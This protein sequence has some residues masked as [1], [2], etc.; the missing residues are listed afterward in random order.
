MSKR[1]RSNTSLSDNEGEEEE[2]NFT[3]SAVTY[4]E[5]YNDPKANVVLVAA[6]GVRFR[7]D[8]FY[9]KGNR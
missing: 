6:D 7:V 2:E 9:L 8:D 3:Q 5:R 4:H 1:T